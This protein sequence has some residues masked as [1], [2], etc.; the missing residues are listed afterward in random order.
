VKLFLR[1]AVLA[2]A[3]IPLA[4]L[5]GCGSSA[6]SAAG[7]SKSSAAAATTTNCVTQATQRAAQALGPLTF[8]GPPGAVNMKTNAGKSIWL[9]GAAQDEFTQT[10]NDGFQAAARAAGMTPHYVEANGNVTQMASLVQQAVSQHARG[11]VLFNIP[12]QAVSGPL[13]TAHA[14]GITVIDFNNGNPTDPLEPGIFAHVADNLTA[15]GAAMADWM[16]MDSRCQLHLATFK[17]PTYPL[18]ADLIAN[19][20]AEVKRLCSNCTVSDQNF[21]LATFATTLGPQAVTLV[22]RD[23]SINYI[24]PG[25][26]AFAGLISPA[27]QQIGS[28]VKLVGHD[29]SASNLK[30][31]A[32]HSTLQVMT[33]AS[34]PELYTGWVLVDELGRG[35]SG[36]PVRDWAL[37]ARLVDTS[38]IGAGSVASIFP[39]Y[40]DYQS[41][42][43]AAWGVG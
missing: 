33:D 32:A 30:A 24:D 21:D 41:A 15:Q 16:L 5:S 42:F 22:R 34:A 4:S 35:M 31:M 6:N 40:Q 19:T 36:D 27:L 18:D 39:N 43:R 14:A 3:I 13:A 29:G 7:P 26:D 25:F 28:H 9:I 1:S 10:V 11:I 12:P 2:A 38:N 23:P 20:I 17:L 37:P 8:Q